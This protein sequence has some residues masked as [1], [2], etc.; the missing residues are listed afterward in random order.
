MTPI[1]VEQI[2]AVLPFLDRF[3]AP[4]FSAGSWKTPDGLFPSFEFAE[5]VGEFQSVLYDHGWVTPAFNWMK[6]Q[7]NAREF[8]NDP[9]KVGRADATTIQKLFTTH[10]R[11][12]RFCEGHLV[13]MFENG[14]ILSLLRRLKVI[15]SEM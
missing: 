7:E 8:E 13:A 3:E 2:D 4:G 14:H 6:W 10:V 15:R 5:I 1:A 12:D 11:A 9:E